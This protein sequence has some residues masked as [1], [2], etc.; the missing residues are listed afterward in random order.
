MRDSRQVPTGVVRLAEPKWCNFCSEW[1][2]TLRDIVHT[3][4]WK[5]N[6]L[7]TDRQGKFVK[8]RS[9][10]GHLE[11]SSVENKENVQIQ[12]SA[13]KGMN[14]MK[15]SSNKSYVHANME[16]VKSIMSL[17]CAIFHLKSIW[18][19][20][21]IVAPTISDCYGCLSNSGICSWIPASLSV[22]PLNQP[23]VIC[24]NRFSL[25]Q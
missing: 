5:G 20:P 3:V 19:I 24:C 16:R 15:N 2:P 8:K 17:C 1:N 6:R 4:S 9:I 10:F 23:A 21:K 14:I 11:N 25:S 7:L 22:Y 18:R 12:V 13:V